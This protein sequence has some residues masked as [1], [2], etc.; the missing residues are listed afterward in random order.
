MEPLGK[1]L[2][3]VE[4][5]G[6]SRR[7]TKMWDIVNKSKQSLGV[8]KWYQHWRKY[9]FITGDQIVLD[10]G[11]GRTIFGFVDKQNQ[12]HKEQLREERVSEAPHE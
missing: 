5:T 2:D 1:Y 8:V 6:D 4:L 11:C 3:A 9:V 7:K 10:S 12:L